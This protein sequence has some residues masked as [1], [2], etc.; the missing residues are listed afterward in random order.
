MKCKFCNMEFEVNKKMHYIARDNRELGLATIAS[1][2]EEK[3]YDAIDCPKCGSQIII[4]ERKRDFGL[5]W[6]KEVSDSL[7]EEEDEG[8][9]NFELIKKMSFEQL[10]DFL[11]EAC[12]SNDYFVNQN[13]KYYCEK[14]INGECILDGNCS[15]L[16]V[17]DI[18]HWLNSKT[19]E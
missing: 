7:K 12:V 10:S 15:E 8:V 19:G 13:C 6:D 4:Q 2:K 5:D 16:D 11:H 1:N 17:D 9:T 3:I 18:D 14:R